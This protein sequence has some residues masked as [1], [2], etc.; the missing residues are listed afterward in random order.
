M[1]V[2][3]RSGYK[4][5]SIVLFG[6]DVFTSRFLHVIEF[7]FVSCLRNPMTVILYITN[8]YKNYVFT[9][10]FMFFYIFFSFSVM[11]YINIYHSVSYYDF[12]FCYSQE[13]DTCA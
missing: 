6:S 2:K 3:T 10:S 4:I 1:V 9:N 8:I 12:T 11:L 13:Q 7:A 5:K